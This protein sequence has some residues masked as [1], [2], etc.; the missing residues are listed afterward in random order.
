MIASPWFRFAR[1][2]PERKYAALVGLAELRSITVVPTFVYY[3]AQIDF[4]LRR[5]PGVVGYRS[6]IAPLG[7]RFYHLSAWEDRDALHRFIRSDPHRRA[8]DTLDTRWLG[9]ATFSYWEVSGS[10]MPLKFSRELFR[11]GP[12]SPGRV[13]YP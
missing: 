9:K 1:V 7:L 5:S 2:D 3:G 4:Q 13:V 12:D 6:A 10:E 11:L 8:M